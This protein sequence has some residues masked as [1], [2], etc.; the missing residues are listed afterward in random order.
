MNKK[1]N[2]VPMQFYQGATANDT[3]TPLYSALL[4]HDNY[5]KLKSGTKNLLMCCIAQVSDKKSKQ[6]VYNHRKEL[7]AYGIEINYPEHMTFVFPT[8]HAE[9]Y[10]IKSSN[11]SRGLKELEEL[12]FIKTLEN[13][14]LRHKMNYYCFD[15]NRLWIK[16]DEERENI[17]TKQKELKK[18]SKVGL[19][20]R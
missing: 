12:G 10:G 18:N 20:H 19:S 1:N 13:N 7:E 4:K 6:C 2:K 8:K 9:E 15:V 5:K 14:Q 17:R 11:L 16:T 3:Y